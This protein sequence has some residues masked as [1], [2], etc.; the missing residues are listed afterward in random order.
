MVTRPRSANTLKF[1]LMARRLN[2]PRSAA[3]MQPLSP[4]NALRHVQYRGKNRFYIVAVPGHPRRFICAGSADRR[5]RGIRQCTDQ[6]YS[7][8]TGKCRWSE[9]C[10]GRSQRDRQRIQ[11]SSAA[12]TA[13]HYPGGSAIQVRKR[14]RFVFV[15]LCGKE[16]KLP[17]KFSWVACQPNCRGW[18]S[19][20]GI[21]IEQ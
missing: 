13:Y 4:S 12:A 20:V 10:K 17:I 7:A 11:D 21:V 5:R 14:P 6:W 8:G 18:V 1:N 9:Y 3:A 16:R 15:G 19:A 2:R